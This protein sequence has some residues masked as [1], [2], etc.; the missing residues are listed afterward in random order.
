MVSNDGASNSTADAASSA[1]AADAAD[2][3]V[4][5]SG[6]NDAANNGA[7]GDEVCSF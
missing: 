2:Q 6:V 3:L 5:A 4:A 7:K 1:D